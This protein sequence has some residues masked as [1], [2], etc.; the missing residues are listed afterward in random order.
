MYSSVATSCHARDVVI[1]FSYSVNCCFGVSA[2]SMFCN[3]GLSFKLFAYVLN[4]REEF[5]IDAVLQ[6]GG[7]LGLLRQHVEELTGLLGTAEHGIGI[8]LGLRHED[9]SLEL[10]DDPF[11]VNANLLEFFVQ[12]FVNHGH[13][14]F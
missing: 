11:R 5:L 3:L 12:R 8:Q 13:H 7:V 4:V 1:S 14:A 6:Y 2:L 9:G 10:F